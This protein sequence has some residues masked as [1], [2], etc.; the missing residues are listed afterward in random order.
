[1]KILFTGHRGFLGRELIPHLKEQGHDVTSS[2]VDYSDERN[3]EFFLRFKKL[4][5]NKNI[6]NSDK[7]AHKVIPLLLNQGFR[8]AIILPH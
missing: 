8:H 6:N 4:M 5:V 1:M 7:T 3:L 2:N